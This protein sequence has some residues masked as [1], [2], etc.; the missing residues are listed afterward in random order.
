MG[1]E[2]SLSTNPR[3]SSRFSDSAP[4]A[5]ESILEALKKNATELGHPQCYSACDMTFIKESADFG[6]SAIIG[7]GFKLERVTRL[8]DNFV[9]AEG[10]NG[11]VINIGNISPGETI[12]VETHLR[13][14]ARAALLVSS[15]EVMSNF[16]AAEPGEKSP[17]TKLA[18]NQQLKEMLASFDAIGFAEFPLVARTNDPLIS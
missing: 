11:V 3:F 15:K 5:V 4:D 10:G 2:F 8:D 14:G 16:F 17:A 1:F 18:E 6:D 12:D 9:L 13:R 7:N